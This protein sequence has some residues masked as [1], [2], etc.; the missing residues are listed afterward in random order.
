MSTFPFFTQSCFAPQAFQNIVSGLVMVDLKKLR[1]VQG[2]SDASSLCWLRRAK[3]MKEKESQGRRRTCT[4]GEGEDGGWRRTGRFVQK[5]N[6][7]V[8]ERGSYARCQQESHKP[9]A[10]CQQV[11]QVKVEGCCGLNPLPTD[12]HRCEQLTKI[13]ILG[14][15]ANNPDIANMAGALDVAVVTIKGMCSRSI[16]TAIT[17]K[18]EADLISYQSNSSIAC[19]IHMR[20]SIWQIIQLQSCQYFVTHQRDGSHC[21]KHRSM[22]RV[23]IRLA[24][25]LISF[26]NQIINLL[27]FTLWQSCNDDEEHDNHTNWR[28]LDQDRI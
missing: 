19:V 14:K 9:G 10:R 7:V 18:I 26:P 4:S 22:H 6:G 23:T 21:Y 15:Q 25:D 16:S 8:P 5:H 20:A 12:M 1:K 17:S 24:P 2:L 28:R 3:G 27:N 13:H 11:G